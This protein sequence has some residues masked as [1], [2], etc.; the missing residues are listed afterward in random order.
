M[1]RIIYL[2]FLFNLTINLFG[3]NREVIKLT[4]N[5]SVSDAGSA[6][7]SVPITLPPGIGGMKPDLS[8]N[9]SSN[10][11]NGLLGI[12][13]A[14]SGMSVI[15]RGNRTI[16]QDGVSYGIQFN[17]DDVFYLDG[18]RLVQWNDISVYGADG[19][20]YGTESNTFVK[21]ISKSTSGEG[22][23]Y[24][25]AYTKS[26]LKLTF[27]RNAS[28]RVFVPGTQTVLYYLLDRMEEYHADNIISQTPKTNYITYE[29]EKDESNATYRPV[30]IRYTQNPNLAPGSNS[31]LT[32]VWFSYQNRN[33]VDEGYLHGIKTS[34][35]QRLFQIVISQNSSVKEVY[36]FYY[37]EYGENNASL[38]KEV[39]HCIQETGDCS[40]PLTFEWDK[41]N[42]ELTFTQK[43][44]PIP[45]SAIKGDKKEIYSQD[46]NNDGLTDIIIADRTTNLR[47]EIW[48]NQ[49]NT[50][51]A[52]INSNLQTTFTTSAINFSDINADGFIDIVITNVSGSN[53]WYIN[54][55]KINTQG[56]N[57]ILAPQQILTTE[58]KDKQYFFIDYNGDSRPD[59]LILDKIAGTLVLYENQ[60]TDVVQFQK[61]SDLSLGLTENILKNNIIYPADLNNDGKTDILIFTK[62][63]KDGTSI[64]YKNQFHGNNEVF[65]PLNTN[66]NKKY[67]SV[68]P[69]T[70]QNTGIGQ[71]S[72]LAY[73]GY[74]YM[75]N[76]N[77]NLTENVLT[78]KFSGIRNP[79]FV[80]LNGDGLLD[81]II[82]MTHNH[83]YQANNVDIRYIQVEKIYKIINKGNFIFETPEIISSPINNID[84]NIKDVNCKLDDCGSTK[85]YFGFFNAYLR[86]N[87]GIA[88]FTR[89]TNPPYNYP[90]GTIYWEHPRYFVDLNGDGKSDLIVR[91]HDVPSSNNANPILFNTKLSNSSTICSGIVSKF[92]YHRTFQMDFG[93]FDKFGTDILIYGTSTGYNSIYIN[94]ANG[95][96][97]V[98][99]GFHGQLGGGINVS[100]STL[101]D[102]NTYVKGTGRSYPDID[103]SSSGLVVQE[104]SKTTS[105]SNPEIIT[106]NT[107]KYYDGVLNLTGRGFRGF[108]KIQVTDHVQGF[109]VVKEFEEDSRLIASNLKSQKTYT[110]DGKIVSEEIY[111]N[112]QWQTKSDGSGQIDTFFVVTNINFQDKIFTPYPA[113]SISKSYDLDGTLLIENKS[114]MHMDVFGN[115][116]YQVFDHGDGCIDSIYN[117]YINEWDK[118]FIGRLSKSTVFKTCPGGTE[119]LRETEFEY[120]PITGYLIKEIL[121]PNQGQEL[122]TIKTYERDKF[123]N[124]TKTTEQAWNGTQVVTRTKTAKFDALGR[125]QI[126]S[127]NQLGQKVSLKV[128]PYRGLPLESTDENGLVTKMKYNAFGILRETEYPDGT[129]SFINSEKQDWWVGWSYS[130]WFEFSTYATNTPLS[131][132]SMDITGR[133]LADFQTLFD[134]G[135]S[136]TSKFYNENRLSTYTYP[137]G[138]QRYEYDVAGRVKKTIQSG[139]NFSSL[140]YT[141]NYVGLSETN[142]NPLQQT[143][144]RV[145]DVRQRLSRAI[146]N[147][148]NQVNYKYDIQ[149]NLSQIIA[150]YNEYIISYEYDL[151]GRMTA[152][153]DPVL[154]REEYRY[155]GFG[156]LLWK[157][158]GK[159][160][161]ISYTYDDLNRVKT[162]VQAEGT[163]EFTYD[164]GNKAVGK[165]NKITYPNYESNLVYDN[166]G[167]I[168]QN[169]IIIQG[170]SYIYR[171]HYNNIGKIDRVEHP[172]GIILKYHYNENFFLAKITNNQS[173]KLLWEINAVDL[174]NRVMEDTLGNGVKTRYEYDLQDNLTRVSSERNGSV[175]HDIEYHFNAINL[176]TSKID[177]KNNITETY[178][179]DNLNRLTHVSTSGQ[180]NEELSMTYDKWG[181]ITSKSDLGTYHYNENIPTLLERIDF[182]ETDCTLPSSK[183]DYDYTSFNKI[184]KISGDSVRLEID[185]GPDNQ[186]LVQR[187]YIH[188]QLRETRIYVAG[189]YEVITINNIDTKRASLPGSAGIA[190]IYEVTGN[191]PGKY[192]YLHKDNQGT[193]VALTN[194]AGIVQYSYQYDVWGKR[195]VTSQTENVYGATYRGYTGHEHIAI[196]ELINMNG[197]I[198][199]PVMARFLSADPYIQDNTNFQNFNRYAYVYNNPVNLTDPSGYWSLKK[200]WNSF[201]KSASQTIGRI[202]SGLS[203]IANGNIRDGLKSFGQAHID[204]YFKWYAKPIHSRGQDVF[205]E[206]TWNQIVVASATITVAYFSGG[207]ASGFVGGALN[208]YLSGA[209]TNDILKAGFKGAV[210]AGISAGLTYGVGS[211]IEA[212]NNAGGNAILGEGLRAVG[213]GAVQ[214]TMNELQ[215]GKFSSG[216]YS[217]AVSSL[218]SHTE[219]FYGNNR[220]VRVFSASLVGGA[221]SSITGGKFA[222]GAVSGAFVEMYNYQMHEGSIGGGGDG[223]YWLSDNVELD[224]SFDRLQKFTDNAELLKSGSIKQHIKNAIPSG[225][226]GFKA[227][228]LLFDAVNGPFRIPPQQQFRYNAPFDYR[229]HG[230]PMPVPGPTPK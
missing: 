24:F 38:L 97:P 118:W 170:K 159:G 161:E 15:S 148:G 12:G 85:C 40:D 116:I 92:E 46:L 145:K 7:Y 214:G 197:R 59:F 180:I 94:D 230:G 98:I 17:R 43:T 149:G 9:Y 70:Y 37:D 171:Y 72:N 211:G 23:G 48:L 188:N 69:D 179:Y 195:R 128:D 136:F 63:D 166:V 229:Y 177:H 111:N 49:G 45:V 13:W 53:S 181:N 150:G 74:P 34:I 223:E 192:T 183:F 11:G 6:T 35:N 175:I 208:A 164:Q 73:N 36:E 10:G 80:D 139:N 201:R 154:G 82:S 172:S 185:Y 210:I 221:S 217:G 54:D 204:V 51:F 90:E 178:S 155:D 19:A 101:N 167:R 213:H 110:R 190:V 68:Y 121:E 222:T 71:N 134:G 112:V 220:A 29:Y 22:P 99:T 187:M 162:I 61:R 129:K 64:I 132:T 107:Y 142:I 105:S 125:Y 79:R 182:F 147:E 228:L 117:E 60:S 138:E 109:K 44:S 32:D 144:T 137:Y 199:D 56:A 131:R 130:S 135:E 21:V 4:G 186:R 157:K 194:D 126:E 108:K 196:L 198:Y 224:N 58:L 209:G 127:T 65:T 93:R 115:V 123:G 1:K 106:N 151:R 119:V 42:I 62:N 96:P 205:G 5:F 52:K 86:Y 3:Q 219:G 226:I 163:I 140:E 100:Y 133:E 50:N 189:D 104:F 216:F 143:M 30:H 28:S 76:N 16:A 14:F 20:E 160:N 88:R 26:G 146:D 31:S 176:K 191:Q 114:R 200:T 218:A 169:T 156:N 57:F 25:E 153:I 124:I 84:I 152:M 33:D 203:S 77:A 55:K 206:E 89:Y 18:E 122:R 158:D 168:S 87:S 141:N 225:E 81:I 66:I 227:G 39:T 2:L 41:P 75:I 78:P 165:L 193:I 202:G 95:R 103:Y 184:S 207:V 67:F 83:W 174:R 8:I 113:E 91:Q 215:G 47:F 120:N 102:P 212:F 173:G 27:G